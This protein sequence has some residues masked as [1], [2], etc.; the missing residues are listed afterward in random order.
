MRPQ[1]P[2]REVR[3]SADGRDD[4]AAHAQSEKSV[5]PK[6][7]T[8]RNVSHDLAAEC[9]RLIGLAESMPAVAERRRAIAGAWYA[10][11]IELTQTASL[12]APNGE[13]KLDGLVSELR[14]AWMST[15]HEHAGVTYRTPHADEPKMLPSRIM[16]A[17]G[18]ERSLEESPLDVR[19]PAYRPVPAGWLARHLLFSSGMAALSGIMQT[20]PAI[21]GPR[22]T[23]PLRP[24]DVQCAA[25]RLAALEAPP[26]LVIDSTLVGPS[27][28][29]TRILDETR[30][31][32]LIVQA[33][34]GLKLDQAGL[35]LANV[36][37][38]SLYAS[39]HG[40]RNSMR[41]KSGCA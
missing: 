12:E 36:G 24:F 39:S 19:L 22:S 20:V 2:S 31:L 32:P 27:L 18:Y 26:L 1:T 11:L 4:H 16:V 33:S 37:I 7:V 41:P 17:Y 5:R 28:P 21:L 9:D 38:V 8:A 15:A 25:R 3:A 40:R 34:S 23:P 10:Q 30:A 14:R 35:E 13:R 6:I 29:M